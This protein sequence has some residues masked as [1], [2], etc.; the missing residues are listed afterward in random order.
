MNTLLEVNDLEVKFKS[1]QQELKALK[2]ISFSV[3]KG[4]TVCIVGESGSGKSITSLSLMRLLPRNGQIS[5]GSIKFK[6]ND[7]VQETE[8][9]LEKIRGKEI[10]M[11]FQE[12]M[13]ALN[14]TFT[15]GYQLKEP[16]VTHQRLSK[17][18][19]KKKSIIMLEKVGIPNPKEKLNVYP[20]ELS[21]GMRQRIMIAMALSCEPSLLIADEP[22]TAL[23][24][25]IQAQILN[26]IEE[27]KQQ[28]EMGIVFVTHDMGVVA[29]IADRVVV[30]YAGEIIE[31]GDVK[32]VFNNPSHPYT[33]KLL[34]SVPAI[35][36]EQPVEGIPGS[37]PSLED[38][39]SGCQFHTRCP[40]AMEKCTHKSPPFFDISSTHESKCWLLEVKNKNEQ[41]S[42]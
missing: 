22:T 28:M 14:P 1:S 31:N 12:P 39:I 23:D 7:I 8:K 2:N 16:L 15:V 17:S 30:M 20:H 3:K 19:A 35:D 6:E 36:K 5:N 33:Q 38:H 13:T 37:M 40:F 18:E 4:E 41:T 34:A 32:N 24:V 29:E 11:I 9:T 42:T 10:S 21:G 26:L 27:L 25:T